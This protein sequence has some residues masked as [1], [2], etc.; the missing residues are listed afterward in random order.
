MEKWIRSRVLCMQEHSK[1]FL[2]LKQTES[3]SIYE[4]NLVNHLYW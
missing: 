3:L 2:V 4:C 1:N